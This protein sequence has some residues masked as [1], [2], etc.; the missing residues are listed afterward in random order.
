M[1]IHD[2]QFVKSSSKLSECPA[3]GRNEYA[4]IGRSNVGKSSLIN[5]LVQR[6]ELAKTSGKPG[7]TTLINHFVINQEENKPDTGW[8]LVDLPGYGYAATSRSN[9]KKWKGFTKDYL[10]ERPTLTFL[11]LLIDSRHS[12]QSNDLDFIQWL[13]EN[14]IPFGIVFTKTDKLTKNELNKNQAVYSK[15]LKETWENLPPI[16][17]TSSAHKSGREEIVNFIE[18]V[19]NG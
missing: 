15:K 13:G 12:P 6:K 5:M 4:F 16:F 18:E 10:K 8:Y 9:R 3:P 1:I 19:N 17:L 7:K 2:A 14:G 11:F